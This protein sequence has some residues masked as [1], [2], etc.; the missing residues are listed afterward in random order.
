MEFAKDGVPFVD[1]VGKRHL[2][3]GFG[4][5]SSDK[6]DYRFVYRQPHILH[7]G[8]G[9]PPTE[10]I[11]DLDSV[12]SPHQIILAIGIVHRFRELEGKDK[13][14]LNRGREENYIAL[15][16]QS[17]QFRLDRGGAELRAGAQMMVG[18]TAAVPLRP[19]VPAP[20]EEAG[21]P[22]A[23]PRRLDRQSGN[24]GRALI[25]PPDRPPSCKEAVES[26]WRG[27]Q[28]QLYNPLV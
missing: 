14:F 26:T 21:R 4:I 3:R 20:H 18:A 11:V 9:D 23:L 7:V 8:D 19:T 16:Q 24:P 2:V 10:Y 25:L 5:R 28:S 22:A 15:A 6:E 27:S 12:S 13:L 1:G 17:V